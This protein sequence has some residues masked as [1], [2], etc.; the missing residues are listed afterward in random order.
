MV[1]N[2]HFSPN[3]KRSNSLELFW[4]SNLTNNSK[5]HHFTPHNNRAV[6]CVCCVLHLLY[7]D[8]CTVCTVLHVLNVMYCVQC[9]YGVYCMYGVCVQFHC[10]GPLCV[11][12]VCVCVLIVCDVLDT[13]IARYHSP[14]LTSIFGLSHQPWHTAVSE[15]L[16]TSL[17]DLLKE[18]EWL[19]QC[20]FIVCFT[21][22]SVSVF[23][24]VL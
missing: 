1:E 6:Y 11:L 16:Y 15:S 22:D 8:V 21:C 12:F 9:V 24:S 19:E 3:V 7:C 23:D 14:S 2:L 4:I 17:G 13:F 10:I 5:L 20:I 18:N